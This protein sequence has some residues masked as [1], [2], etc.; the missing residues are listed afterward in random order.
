LVNEYFDL[1]LW[2]FYSLLLWF[3]ALLE[4]LLEKLLGLKLYYRSYFKKSHAGLSRSI[5]SCQCD[6]GL[7]RDPVRVEIKIVFISETR[8]MHDGSIMKMT[9]DLKDIIHLNLNYN[10]L[11]W[12][13]NKQIDNLL[14]LIKYYYLFDVWNNQ[15]KTKSL[16]RGHRIHDLYAFRWPCAIGALP[17]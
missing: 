5:V 7:E 10:L 8:N 12:E 13:I 2:S 4:K 3:V 11:S 9:I 15:S 14:E 6:N 1:L 16:F 17:L